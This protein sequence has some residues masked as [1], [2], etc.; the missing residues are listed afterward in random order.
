M[1]TVTITKE[2]T[3][4]PAILQRLPAQI[5][6]DL[7]ARASIELS[8]TASYEILT[9]GVVFV[10]ESQSTKAVKTGKSIGISS[11]PI[12]DTLVLS[13]AVAVAAA[14]QIR[15]T[16]TPTAANTSSSQGSVVVGADVPT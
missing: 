13:G 15:V 12:R 5:T 1:E 14:V 11:T 10:G 4:T 8:A 3:F 9:P 7:E 16:L 6:S 2:L